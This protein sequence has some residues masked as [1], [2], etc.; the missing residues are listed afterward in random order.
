MK[1][2]I[3]I[4]GTFLTIIAIVFLLWLVNVFFGN[5]ISRIMASKAAENHLAEN[6]SDRDFF[7]ETINYSFKDGNYYAHIESP[8]S[9]DSNFAVS[10]SLSGKVKGDSYS[11]SVL[12]GWNT[13][14]RIGEEYRLIVD[15]VF[16]PD[17]FSISS[18]IAYG[19][20]YKINKSDLELDK[21]YDIKELAKKSGKIV[22]Y[23]ED[24]L[25]TFEKASELLII[26]KE[27]FDKADVPFYIIDFVL[28]K[29]L[30]EEVASKGQARI[31]IE[32]FL[33]SDIYKEGL[34]E[35]I[36]LAH[37]ARL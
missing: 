12:D 2:V 27:A 3:K 23:A 26:I 1:K 20:F 4:A 28:E 22:F 5:P 16:T 37:E 36:E 9:I 11:S 14:R 6:Y 10:I 18:N 33:S 15:K 29:P 24:D 21:K 30:T 13:Y 31:Y 19:K 35:R 7:I 8:S 32:D 25:V 34:E 17:N